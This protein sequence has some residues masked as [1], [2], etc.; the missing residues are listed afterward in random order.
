[1]KTPN[2][3]DKKG[4]HPIP[5]AEGIAKDENSEKMKEKDKSSDENEKKKD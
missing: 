1:M 4:K 2:Y 3:D 5:H